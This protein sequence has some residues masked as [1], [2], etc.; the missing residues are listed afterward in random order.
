LLQATPPRYAREM[1]PVYARFAA[2]VILDGSRLAAIAHRL[3]LLQLE[4]LT[5]NVP[6]LL[7]DSRIR[8]A[9]S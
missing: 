5:V 7:S 4:I 6:L 8:C 2:V 1:A 3:K 9:T